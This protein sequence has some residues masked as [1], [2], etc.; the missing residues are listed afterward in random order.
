MRQ[1][2]TTR[3]FTIGVVGPCASG[4]STLIRR[5]EALGYRARHIAQEHSDVP[6]MWQRL[7]RPDFLVFLDVSF[8]IATA[9][10]NLWWREEEYQEQQRRLAHAR[11]HA[12]VVI[13]TD[14]LTPEEV[15]ARVLEALE[16]A[17]APPPEE[18]AAG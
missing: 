15:L 8:P 14:D 12:D 16:A 3:P 10:R 9:R 11:A 7:S 18:S 17:G 2:K 6:D 1:G 4:K 5:L 13:V